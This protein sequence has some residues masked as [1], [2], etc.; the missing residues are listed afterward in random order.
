[1]HNT[2]RNPLLVAGIF[3]LFLLLSVS[4]AEPAQ[5]N[6][7]GGGGNCGLDLDLHGAVS[8]TASDTEIMAGEPVYLT[9]YGNLWT[10][11]C[12]ATF[13][14]TTI[15][16]ESDDGMGN[17]ISN[18]PAGAGT[19]YPTE[20]TTYSVT[21]FDSYWT[22]QGAAEHGTK[23]GILGDSHTWVQYPS[24]SVSVTVTQPVQADLIPAETTA[25]ATA[26]V[27]EAVTL[28]SSVSNFGETAANNFPNIFQIMTNDLS[29]TVG[30]S[31]AQTLSLAAG[32]AGGQWI[33][34]STSGSGKL[35]TGGSP[36]TFLTSCPSSFDE[37]GSCSVGD[38]CFGGDPDDA[39]SICPDGGQVEYGS[40]RYT[41]L[42]SS[43][44]SSASISS[45]Y[46][47][48]T[49]GTYQVR[50]CADNNTSWAGTVTESN[51]NN[52]CTD[53][54]PIVV[55]ALDTQCTD[56]A[57]NDGDG[58]IDGLDGGCDG[59][60]ADD[61]EGND[62][63][64]TL[65]ANPTQVVL[66][67]T[68]TLTWDCSAN[69]TSASIN[70]SPVTTLSPAN[71]NGTLSTGSLESP[72]NNFQLTCTNAHSSDTDTVSITTSNPTV[73]L[74][75][76]AKRVVDGGSTTL[77]WDGDQVTSCSLTGSNGLTYTAGTDALN[78]PSE[79]I[80]TQTTFIVTCDGGTATDTEIVN[81]PVDIDE[82]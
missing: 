12:G 27:G 73:D 54:V 59:G 39:S 41:C 3:S 66:G 4:F 23:V 42:D 16:Y 6:C 17:V 65:S 44:G 1:M 71:S 14:Y 9:W 20:T 56:S 61:D 35:C 52:N 74:T 77:T 68:S 48:T 36:N 2:L 75:V 45:S 8:L 58:D 10:T 43:G 13:P 76:G 30:M 72:T 50:A 31:A 47:F 78:I 5:A 49:A 63:T 18:G 34:T 29:T 51:E 37:G 7:F 80:T 25:P 67:N 55:S 79:D 15:P 46:T 19:E 11:N 26:Q 33:Q 28:S 62:P 57:D 60:D 40:P 32:G 64:A 53:W 38:R 81:T 82:F 69:T 24:S 21:C 70:T 22:P